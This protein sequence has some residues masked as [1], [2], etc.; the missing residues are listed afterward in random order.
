MSRV[1]VTELRE[2]EACHQN[3]SAHA[4]DPKAKI[5]AKIAA[6]TKTEQNSICG[7]CHYNQ[8]LFKGRA[9]NP[10]TSTAS[11]RTWVR[12][13]S[14]AA[15]VPGL[16][17]SHQGKS[18]MLVRIKAHICYKCHTGATVTMAIFQPFSH[19]TFGKACQAC[20]AVHGGSS[21]AQWA[22]MG[23]GVCVICHF[24]GGGDRRLS[25]NCGGRASNEKGRFHEGVFFFLFPRGERIKV[26]GGHGDRQPRKRPFRRLT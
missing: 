21:G 1:P 2:C 26:R 23:T 7:K 14:A 10:T 17:F 4:A 9:I 16:P 22:R 24:V 3:T 13:T 5:P 20:H 11:T 19:L 6:L 8:E 18:E 12:R 15:L 25:P